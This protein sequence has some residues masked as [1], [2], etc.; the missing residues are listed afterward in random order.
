MA[1]MRVVRKF[2]IKCFMA[3]HI[4]L[5]RQHAWV[6]SQRAWVGSQGACVG[7]GLLLGTACL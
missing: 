2:T 4:V 5:V 6:G 1:E 3:V 7:R